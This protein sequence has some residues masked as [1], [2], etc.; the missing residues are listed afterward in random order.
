MVAA[1]ALLASC[2]SSSQSNGA[3]PQGTPAQVDLDRVADDA[4]TTSTVDTTTTTAPPRGP[5][6]SGEAVTIAFAGDAS[7]EGLTDAVRSDPEGLLG[8]ITPLLSSADVTVIN[9]EAALGM[10]GTAQ[11][12]AFAFRTPAET[13]VALR[14]AGVDAVS[15]A[16]N[17]GMD[18]GEAGFA[19]S[20]RIK[21]ESGFPI[22]GMGN[23][24][25]EAYA[26]FLTEVKG[27]RIGVIAATDVLNDHL[28]A[29]W[30]AGPGKPGLASA[31][32]DR[33]QRLVQEID[34]TRDKVD[35]LAVYLH[36]GI[37]KQTCPS[38]RQRE[39]A[40]T[41]TAAGADIVVGAHPHRLQG[42]GFLG[43]KFVAYSLSNFIFQAP[44]ADGRRTGV[45][46]VTATGR[47]IDGYQ[48]HPATITNRVPVPLDGAS[49]EKEQASMTQLQQCADLS[50]T[51]SATPAAGQEP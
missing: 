47:H 40:T 34:A 15:M 12:K 50:P 44:S 11:D 20:L 8:A 42:M 39:L 41:L 31:K 45:A 14:S 17:H 49:A 33:L 16:N 35:T 9:L 36:W 28:M 6:G 18:F 21:S 1:T 22:I 38:D 7:F 46:V 27:Q 23:D 29:T 51:P 5:E 24:E 43:D 2:S 3:S 25:A 37:E 30:T 10:A 13:V 4:A 32:G 26:P 19:E 48:W